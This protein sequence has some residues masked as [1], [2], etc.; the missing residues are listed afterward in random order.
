MA[1]MQLRNYTEEAVKLYVDR[2]F[3]DTDIC[4]CDTCKLDVM[5]IM[6]NNLQPK[7]VVTDKGALYAKLEDFDPQ[8]KVDYMTEMTNAVKQVKEYSRHE[9]K[10]R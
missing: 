9:P 8:Y 10:K 2:W 1:E 5:A 4:N 7:Y 3:R 6:L